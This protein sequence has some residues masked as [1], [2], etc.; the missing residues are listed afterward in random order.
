MHP[1]HEPTADP[2]TEAPTLTVLTPAP[3]HHSA[4]KWAMLNPKYKGGDGELLWHIYYGDYADDQRFDSFR[5]NQMWDADGMA[6]C[7]FVIESEYLYLFVNCDPQI[8]FDSSHVHDE[9]WYGHFWREMR[10]M[11]S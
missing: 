10:N 3:T 8:R 2:T 6:L 5:E 9:Q 4:K 11:E 1:T 7:Q